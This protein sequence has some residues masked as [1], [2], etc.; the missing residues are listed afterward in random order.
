MTSFPTFMSAVRACRICRDQP[1]Y[2]P[3][4]DHEPRPILQASQ[5]AR[6]CIASQAPGIRAHESGRPFDDP[7]GVRLRQW[8]EMSETE[9]YDSSV[10][11]I[12]PMGFCFPGLNADGGDLPP[13]RECAE[14]WRQSLFS[15]LPNL[16]LLL[17]IGGYAHRWHFGPTV[18][19]KSV[20]ETV[21]AWRQ[22]YR[23]DPSLRRLPLPHPSWHNNRWLK[24]NPW[25][26]SE[27]LPV[28]REEIRALLP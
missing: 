23:A 22:I 1:R 25:F 16:K 18:A 19:G 26:E 9:F 8:L 21:Q 17:V 15:R 14:A 6:I 10:V 24:H 5:E 13:R 3:P 2:R 27:L 28:L 4:L 12:V 20:S 11:A 7:S